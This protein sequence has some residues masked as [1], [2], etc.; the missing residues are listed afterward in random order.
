MTLSEMRI[1][2]K[3]TKRVNHPRY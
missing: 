1:S 2:M 3:K